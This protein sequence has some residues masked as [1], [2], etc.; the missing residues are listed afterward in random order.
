MNARDSRAA[1]CRSPRA[2]WR[3]RRSWAPNVCRHWRLGI[4]REELPAS[5]EMVELISNSMS[6]RKRRRETLKH[7]RSSS[8]RRSGVAGR[9]LASHSCL[10]ITVVSVCV[11]VTPVPWQRNLILCGSPRSSSDSRRPLDVIS[12][13]TRPARGQPGRVGSVLTS[14]ARG[15]V[16]GRSEMET[17]IDLFRGPRSTPWQPTVGGF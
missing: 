4:L 5:L 14:G 8:Q 3:R 17:C 1:A 12:V 6:S 10:L 13:Y 9:I 7:S 2:R 11:A 15:T 16:R